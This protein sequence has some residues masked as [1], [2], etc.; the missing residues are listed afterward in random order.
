MLENRGGIFLS[1]GEPLDSV[2]KFDG[3]KIRGL[4]GVFDAGL[5]A[6]G[7]VPTAMTS[8]DEYM[9]LQTGVID[10]TVTSPGT[11]LGR[12]FYEVQDYGVYAPT[13]S[14]TK[15]VLVVNPGWW[16]DLPEDVRAVIQASADQFWQESL[17]LN[18]NYRH[19]PN[20]AELGQTTMKVFIMSEDQAEAMAEIMQPAVL[21]AFRKES[22]D[23]D[24]FLRALGN[25]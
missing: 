22:R 25:D 4:T 13:M 24:T 18:M 1:K 17:N 20:M 10:A 9:S 19:D 12:K 5:N 6:L 7:A 8:N 23:A 15:D 11:T 14:Y 3:K 16:E 2:E 21:E